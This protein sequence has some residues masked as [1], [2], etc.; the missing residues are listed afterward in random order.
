MDDLKEPFSKHYP[1]RP[2]LDSLGLRITACGQFLW[3]DRFPWN[4]LADRFRTHRYVVNLAVVGTCVVETAHLG[5][6]RV[7]P[8]AF[9]MV[10]PEEPLSY[11]EPSPDIHYRY[12]AFDGPAVQKAED[13]FR[14]SRSIGHLR[15]RMRAP[16]LFE[17]A[18]QCSFSGNPENERYLPGLLHQILDECYPTYGLRTRTPL[19]DKIAEIIKEIREHPEHDWQFHE[20]ARAAGID[21]DSFRLRFRKFTSLPPTQ[22]LLRERIASARRYLLSGLNVQE[23]AEKS[24][25]SD[26]FYFS[27]Q[28]KKLTGRSPRDYRGPPS[29][30]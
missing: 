22:F 10:F 20:V 4:F 13:R 2:D 26:P 7:T 23:T 8:G 21:Y 16:D 5:A 6:Q 1:N 30:K 18:M 25:F 14:R 17:E 24:G 15:G 29:S 19:D 12:I 9:W 27:R 11:R 3:R 28:F